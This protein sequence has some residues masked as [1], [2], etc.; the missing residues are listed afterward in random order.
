MP[1]TLALMATMWVP[2][3]VVPRMPPAFLLCNNQPLFQFFDEEM[4][5]LDSCRQR[6]PRDE[7]RQAFQPRLIGDWGRP[8]GRTVPRLLGMHR[9]QGMLLHP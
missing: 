6:L 4:C 9:R 7:T 1:R 5:E 2:L 8:H 3:A